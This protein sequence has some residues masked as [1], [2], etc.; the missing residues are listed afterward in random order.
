MYKSRMLIK[1]ALR[2]LPPN[3]VI[4]Y[5]QEQNLP[6]KYEKILICLDVYRFSIDKTADY[7]NISQWTALKYHKEALD[8][9]VILVNMQTQ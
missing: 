7:M 2:T 3:M 5:I 8:K 9:L 4:K 6:K 1:Q